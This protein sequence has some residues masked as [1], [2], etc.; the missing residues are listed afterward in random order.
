VPDFQGGRSEQTTTRY[1]SQYRKPKE[2]SN[3]QGGSLHIMLNFLWRASFR[4]FALPAL[5]SSH[6]PAESAGV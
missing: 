3:G 4:D 6:R 5:K 2:D 1:V